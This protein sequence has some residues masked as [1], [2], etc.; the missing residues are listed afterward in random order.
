MSHAWR[1]LSSEEH[2]QEIQKLCKLNPFVEAIS[3]DF[4]RIHFVR[5]IAANCV[6]VVIVNQLRMTLSFVMVTLR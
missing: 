4:Q 2:A 6:V 5:F 3:G 1:E